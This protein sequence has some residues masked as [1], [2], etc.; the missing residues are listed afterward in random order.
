MESY[1]YLC[2]HIISIKTD[3]NVKNLFELIGELIL[4][5]KLNE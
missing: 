2:K 4:I 3:D 5:G 1:D